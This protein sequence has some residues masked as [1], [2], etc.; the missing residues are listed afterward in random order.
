MIQK[1][2]TLFL[3]FVCLTLFRVSA[4][5]ASLLLDIKPGS[6]DGVEA[7]YSA[8]VGGKY[9]FYGR[10]DAE[11]SELWATDGT[12]AGTKMVKD[13]NPGDLSACDDYPLV[14]FKGKVWFG[15]TTDGFQYYLWSSDGTAAGTVQLLTDGR[16]YL[17]RL[18]AAGNNYLYFVTTTSTNNVTLWQTDGTEAGTKKV[19]EALGSTSLQV[20]DQIVALGDECYLSL[21]AQI[22]K[23]DGTQAGTVMVKDISTGGNNFGDIAEL[24]VAGNKVFFAGDKNFSSWYTPWVS[25]GTPAGTFELAQPDPTGSSSPRWFFP[26]KNKVY[27]SAYDG[28]KQALWSTDGTKAGTALFKDVVVAEFGNLPV[29]MAADA[30]YLY[31]AGKTSTNGKELWR[32]DGTAA[33]TQMVKDLD[34]GSFSSSPSEVAFG[35]GKLYFQANVG[36]NGAELCVSDG[37]NAGTKQI[38]DFYPN[39]ST[40]SFPHDIRQVGN[41]LVFMASHPIHGKELFVLDITSGLRVPEAVLDIALSPN[42]VSGPLRV[43]LPPSADWPQ[44]RFRLLDAGGAVVWEGRPAGAVTELHLPVLP[45]GIYWMEYADAAAH[46][47]RTAVTLLR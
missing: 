23:T 5:Q 44:G 7:E 19:T 15:A 32:T 37:T 47:G 1:R 28:S 9:F 39:S 30:N 43:T 33:N 20:L 31:F 22:W 27:F 16:L 34:P 14:V 35:N 11:G 40:S 4:Q 12:T 17:P 24:N 26:F 36:G 29:D 2:N 38:T 45:A 46:F 13:I 6:G 8:V 3:F 41:N 10:T 42:P 25:D 21:R 18:I